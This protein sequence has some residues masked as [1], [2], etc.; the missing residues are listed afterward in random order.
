VPELGNWCTVFTGQF[1]ITI[2]KNEYGIPMYISAPLTCTC[3][4]ISIAEII[5]Y[6]VLESTASAFHIYVLRYSI[7][8]HLSDVYS[9]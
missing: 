6:R 1:L 3:L 8:S 7:F 5:V 4:T 2:A 9:V